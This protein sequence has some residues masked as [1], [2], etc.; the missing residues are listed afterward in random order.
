MTRITLKGGTTL[1][2]KKAASKN[3]DFIDQLRKLEQKKPDK[4][5]KPLSYSSKQEQEHS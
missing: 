2:L 5:E 4:P 3:K 1:Y